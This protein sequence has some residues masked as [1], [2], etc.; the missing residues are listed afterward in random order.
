MK[1]LLL[2]GTS[3][4]IKL[5][6]RLIIDGYEVIYSIKGLVRHPSL[7]CQIH[8]GGFGGINGLLNYIQTNAI[9]CLVDATHPYAVNMSHHAD[10]VAQ[11]SHLPCLHY[12]RPAWEKRPDDQWIDFSSMQE[13]ASLLLSPIFLSSR[14]FFSMGQLSIDFLAQ[15]QSHQLYLVR[16][17]IEQTQS[18]DNVI[19]IKSIGPFTLSHERQLFKDYAID[20]LI[21]K[22]SGGE[23]VSAKI[24]VARE[25]KIPV[26]M[27]KRPDL[28]T[29]QPIFNTLDGLVSELLC[30]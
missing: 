2:G 14:L 18:I 30:L 9:D 8:S 15:K 28:Q 6:Q 10:M 23:S 29:S 3:D 4:A 26:F 27:Q 16:T 12:L 13:L 11:K 7:A 22:N 19:W 20:A 24:Q 17:A 1:I 21:S 25:M 5:C